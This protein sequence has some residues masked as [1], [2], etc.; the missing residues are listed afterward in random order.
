M[1]KKGI[2]LAFATAII[3]GAA[4]FV[5]KLGVSAIKDP[6]FYTTFKN[7]LVSVFLVSLLLGLG[8][9]KEIKKLRIKDWAKLV[10]IGIVGGSVP[11]VLFFTGLAQTSAV[12]ASFIHKTLFIWVAILAVPFLSEKLN[13]LQL[14]GFGL[15]F[16]GNFIT[17][18]FGK[19]TFGN[20]EKMIIA[21]TV[22]WA[23]ENIIAKRAL[24]KID[25]DIVATGRMFIGSIILF[26]VSLILGKG[27]LYT[28]INSE[29]MFWFFVTSAF[30]LGYVL[31][32]YK[33]LK[34]APVTAVASILTFAFP[35]TSLL[36]AVFIDHKYGL[37][38]LVSLVVVTLG[39]A[40][41][42]GI[43]IILSKKEKAAFST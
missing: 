34:Y 2:Y 39:V 43:A 35:V 28:S 19:F 42:G 4:N 32:W 37:D 27:N 8:K 17:G 10:L 6:I 11:F 5:N 30:L 29:Q 22:L 21:A 33:A 9:F 13:F 20:G 36:S 25:A 18:G 3:S 1:V 14:L 38:Q 16:A 41:V 40:V 23:I 26:V 12:N 15:L 24:R 31:T 7:I